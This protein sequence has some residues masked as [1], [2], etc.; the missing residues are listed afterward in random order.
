[1]KIDNTLV[2]RLLEK[3]EAINTS[4]DLSAY[5]ENVIMFHLRDLIDGKF[6]DGCECTPSGA[7]FAHYHA[8]GL[9]PS[10]HMLLERMRN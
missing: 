5:S 10:G 8:W 1:M 2:Y 7:Q 9:T 3:H 6:L 4:I